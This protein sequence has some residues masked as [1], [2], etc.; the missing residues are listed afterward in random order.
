MARD[1]CVPVYTLDMR[2]HG[3]SPH[4]ASMSYTDMAGDVERFLDDHGLENAAL[5]GHS[6]GG[7]V[8]MS[9]VLDAKLTPGRVSRLISVDISPA[10]GKV[11]MD[12]INYTQRMIEIEEAQCTSRTEADEMLQTVEQDAVVRQFLLT[13]L[14]RADDGKTLRF[15]NPL[16]LMLPTLR[17]IGGFPYA[18]GDETTPPERTWPGRMLLIKGEKSKFVNPRS[19]AATERFFPHME[20][21]SMDTG[22]W[23]QAEQ[24]GQFKE[25][26]RAFLGQ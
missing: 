24:P 6:L 9:A 13:N 21:V 26:V 12:F 23:C 1:F 20:M 5:I 2:N 10:E 14:V 18:V 15:R 3:E 4:S 7:K 8:V 19:I 22:H 17:G 25:H 16:R 11:S